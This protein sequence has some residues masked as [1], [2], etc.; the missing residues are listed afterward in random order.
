MSLGRTRLYWI[1]AC[2]LLLAIVGFFLASRR[3]QSKSQTTAPTASQQPDTTGPAV[4]SEFMFADD[5]ERGGIEG[6]VVDGQGIGVPN[7]I[8]SIM[9]RLVGRDRF[10]DW[11]KKAS[12]RRTRTDKDGRY[13]VDDVAPGVLS[14][15][16]TAPHFLPGRNDRV[17][18]MPGERLTGVD[19][20]VEKGGIRLFGSVSD[21][22][23]GAIV[24]AQIVLAGFDK[25][26]VFDEQTTLFA[27][28]TESDGNGNYEIYVAPNWYDF[29][30]TANGYAP[31]QSWVNVNGD[32]RRD[33]RLHAASRITGHVLDGDGKG[34]ADATVKIRSETFFRE[35]S[36]VTADDGS[37]ISEGL[38]PGRYFLEAQKG[39]LAARAEAPVQVGIG[40]T[41]SADITL[42]N[43]LTIAGKVEDGNGKPVS[44]ARIY[45]G[46]FGSG[47]IYFAPGM[48][49]EK[50]DATTGA[51]GRYE[52]K[53]ILGPWVRLR[54][55]ADGAETKIWSEESVKTDR[56]DVNFILASAATLRVHVMG[57][58]RQPIQG[59]AAYVEVGS[60]EE[61]ATR[62]S[63]SSKTASDGNG[64]VE[65]TGLPGGLATVS[66]RSMDFGSRSRDKVELLSGKTTDLTIEFETPGSISG[67]VK[68]DDGTPAANVTTVAFAQWIGEHST[69]DTAGSFKIEKLGPGEYTVMAQRS[70]EQ[71]MVSENS[72]PDARSIRK[73]TL[74]AG[75][76]AKNIVLQL[77]RT[78]LTIE[79]IV[80]GPGNKPIAGAQVGAA[81]GRTVRFGRCTM[82]FQGKFTS[83]A[84]GHFKIEKL[85]NGVYGVCASQPGFSD[86]T[87]LNVA[88]GSRGVQ[89][90]LRQPGRISGIVVDGEGQPV[91]AASIVASPRQ[92]EF[93]NDPLAEI[94]S[95]PTRAETRAGAFELREL[96]PAVWDIVAQTPEGQHGLARGVVVDEGSE[97]TGL[98]IEL[99]PGVTLS[100][101]LLNAETGKPIAGVVISSGTGALTG[102]GQSDKN[103]SDAQGRYRVANAT[104][105]MKVSI[106]FQPPVALSLLFDDLEAWVPADAKDMDLGAFHLTPG[107]PE[108]F[109]AVGPRTGLRI[110]HEGGSPVVTGI[111][112]ESPAAK[113]GVQVR[114]R[115]LSIDGK[116]I[117]NL[118]KA[119]IEKM[120]T[121]EEGK[122]ATVRVQTGNDAPRDVVIPF[123]AF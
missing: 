69:T 94:K 16:A 21:S 82:A 18:L 118:G 68:W 65:I 83:D 66:I 45:G 72:R 33:V 23:G 43:G 109:L 49:A 103:V 40:T 60:M 62:V 89:V 46:G 87:A 110:R 79:G 58:N 54:A 56:K 13:Q 29:I 106:Y 96:K 101:Q 86:G 122:S 78:D 4:A 104:R 42:K 95:A 3:N 57:P 47:F 64:L 34:V 75:E 20:K 27:L 55:E 36:A 93:N 7:A 28:Q 52:L 30:A 11:F 2:L 77:R 6:R 80:V 119:S 107:K 25:T 81:D 61:W 100:G 99:E 120:M 88:A 35:S 63:R 26:A 105:G 114:D 39:E 41:A 117:A 71:I 115:V 70:D 91:K 22:G 108:D 67:Q 14:L 10:G 50:P 102:T 85:S 92:P 90:R 116:S 51:D 111:F 121:G 123:A 59:A 19:I 38:D 48:D 31:E 1:V 112:E 9:P 98:R 44:G 5:A 37:Y 15:T 53:G 113:S 76:N 32:L 74:A 97:I 24:G 8:V 17:K 12:P 73:L 84:N